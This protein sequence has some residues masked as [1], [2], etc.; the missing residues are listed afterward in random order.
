[1]PQFIKRLNV[2]GLYG[3]FDIDIGF[4]ENVNIVYGVNGAGK[5]TMLHML[6]NVANLDLERFTQLPFKSVKLEIGEGPAI[7]ITCNPISTREGFQRVSLFI[8]GIRKC[9]WP[10]ISTHLR[11]DREPWFAP[12]HRPPLRTNSLAIVLRCQRC[13]EHH[14]IET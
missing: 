9:D 3:R 2:V 10:P 7:A 8:D 1:M 14:N 5:T 4:T 12:H 13:R 11:Q 6:A